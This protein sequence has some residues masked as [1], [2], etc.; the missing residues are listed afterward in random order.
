MS[1]RLEVVNERPPTSRR[2]TAEGSTIILDTTEDT[3]DS[4]YPFLLQRC[5]LGVLMAFLTGILDHAW[6]SDP[7]CVVSAS[8]ILPPGSM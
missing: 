5:Q 4:E 7:G 1:V 8:A 6:G 2:I 3:S